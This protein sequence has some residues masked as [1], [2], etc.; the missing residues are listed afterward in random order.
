MFGDKRRYK[1]LVANGR[2]APAEVTAAKEGLV[3]HGAGDRCARDEGQWKV[4]VMVSPEHEQPFE[5]TFERRVYVGNEVLV[6]SST[7]VLYD[8]GDHSKVMRGTGRRTAPSTKWLARLV[9]QA[10]AG[11]HRR[12]R[13]RTE[14]A[15]PRIPRGTTRRR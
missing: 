4:T 12:H 8:P 15:S 11:Q 7:F 9:L 2:K 1:K 5:A 13:R 6:G 10:R 14:E 3:D